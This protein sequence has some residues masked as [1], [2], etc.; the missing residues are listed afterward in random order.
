M[1]TCSA[2][3]LNQVI[4]HGDQFVDAGKLG[5]DK[6]REALIIREWRAY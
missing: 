1:N 3:S 4:G 5:Y 2:V 6:M